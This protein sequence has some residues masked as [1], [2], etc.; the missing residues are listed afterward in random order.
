MR[1]FC[2]QRG[3]LFHGLHLPA[4]D[5]HFALDGYR[6]FG[7]SRS[8]LTLAVVRERLRSPRTAL[9]FDHPGPARALAAL[10]RALRGRY[11]VAILG[12]DV[13]RELPASARAALA[14]A[15]LVVAISETTAALAAPFLPEG[16]SLTVVHPGIEP[17]GA[18]GSP[19]RALL[20]AVGSDYV[21]VVGRLSGRERYK[22]HDELLDA[23][24]TLAGRSSAIRLVVVGD[25][26]DRARLEARAV[27]LGVA[28]RVVFTGAVTAA[29]LEALYERA[30][31]FAMPSRLEGF[32]LVFVEAMAAGK[33]CVALADTAPAEIVRH[34]ET[35]LLVPGGDAAALADALSTL[36]GDPEQARRMGAAGRARFEAE[37]SQSAFEQRFKPVLVELAG[38]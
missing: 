31:L 12:I 27:A 20:A 30:A 24:A 14:G 13:W 10:P 9:F 15:T 17:R 28:A 38:R 25:G 37:F 7:G 18:G 32:G 5:G 8:R 33:P 4:G 22:G 23:V 19:D 35:G 1:R 21:L 16:V 2:A 29:T 34:G 26:A 11:A 3:L 36:L 6:S